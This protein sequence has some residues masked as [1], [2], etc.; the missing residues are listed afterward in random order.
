MREIAIFAVLSATVLSAPAQ[1]ISS[2]TSAASSLSGPVSPGEIVVINGSSIGPSSLALA[3]IGGKNTLPTSLSGV[4]VTFNGIVAPIIFAS[5]SQ[6][7]VQV[8]YELTGTTSASVSLSNGGQATP[9][10]TVS[11]AP[12]APGLFT[13]DYTGVGQVTALTTGGANS[14]TNPAHKGTAVLL[15][16]TGEGVTT[17][18]G[19]DGT[20]Q[21]S[22]VIRQPV[23]PVS[24]Q[25]AG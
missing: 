24:V 5:G 1:T 16:A 21:T 23:Q 3:P 18:V 2:I 15:F 4:S 25:I 13:L 11:V 10:F 22:L 6:T 17:P 7:S 8:P 9:A 19:V 20:I 14:S 12:A